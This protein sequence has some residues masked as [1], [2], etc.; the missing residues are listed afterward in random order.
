MMNLWHSLSPQVDNRNLLIFKRRL[1]KDKENKAAGSY[2]VHS[3]SQKP[4]FYHSD[5][6]EWGTANNK[7]FYSLNIIS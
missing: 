7:E 6:T 4:L 2:R 5:K 1:D 3:L